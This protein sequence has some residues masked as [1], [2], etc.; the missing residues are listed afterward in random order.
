MCLRYE[1]VS[2]ESMKSVKFRLRLKKRKEYI[3]KPAEYF[4]RMQIDLRAGQNPI[5]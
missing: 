1:T 4:R 3:N 5:K 2:N